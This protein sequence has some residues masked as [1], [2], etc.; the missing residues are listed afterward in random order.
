MVKFRGGHI[1]ELDGIRGVALVMLVAFHY[2]YLPAWDK[3]EPGSVLWRLV[4]AVELSWSCILLFFVLSGFLIGGLLMDHRAAPNFFSAFYIRRVCR[5]FPIYFLWL[6]LFCIAINLDVTRDP[7]QPISWL[8]RDPLPLWGY[9]TYTQNF[10]M[11]AHHSF[12]PHWIAIS[13]SLAIE[14]QFYML[15]PLL[16]YFLPHKKLPYVMLPLILIGPIFRGVFMYDE[17]PR[18][19]AAYLLAPGRFDALFLGVLCAWMVRDERWYRILTDR[20]TL[21]YALAGLMFA[22]VLVIQHYG[23]NAWSSG[24]TTFGY[25]LFAVFYACIL[26][27]AVGHKPGL[28][29][30]VLRLPVLRK[31]GVLSYCVYIIHQ[32]VDGMVHALILGQ[33]PKLQNLTDLAVAAVALTVTFV[34]ASLSWKYFEKPIIN[35]G[36]S[37]RYRAPPARAAENPLT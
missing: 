22:G 35:L 2:F 16:V 4:H 10:V 21:I 3:F 24:M 37:Y 8:F 20:Q 12:G 19:M 14:E 17:S 18:W 7:A 6:F 31:M 33:E 30:K 13:W 11:V 28:M 34:L 26:L 23:G 32:G 36:Y 15:L 29:G 27:I 9:F 5:I 25:A 1:P